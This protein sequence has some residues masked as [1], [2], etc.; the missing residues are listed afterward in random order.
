MFESMTLFDY[1][2]LR[3]EWLLLFILIVLI[4]KD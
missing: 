2:M 1:T 3:V 4:I